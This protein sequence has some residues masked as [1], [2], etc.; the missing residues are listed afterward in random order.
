MQR[1]SGLLFIL[2]LFVILGFGIVLAGGSRSI[3]HQPNYAKITPLPK[4]SQ[5]T[6]YGDGSG[7]ANTTV[8]NGNPG[9]SNNLQLENFA[10]ITATPAPPTPTP[11]KHLTCPPSDDNGLEVAPDCRC[12]DASVTC[13]NGQPFGDDGKPLSG[14]IGSPPMQVDRL[15][16]SRF[17]PGD[18]KYCVAKPVIYLYPSKPTYVDVKVISTGQVTISDPFYPPDGWKNVFAYPNGDLLYHATKYR[19]LFYETE[20]TTYKKPEKGIVIPSRDLENQLNRILDRLGLIGTEK[21]EFLEFWVPKLLALKSPYIFFSLIDQSEKEKIDKVI[22]LPKPTMSIAFLA[23]FKPITDPST[24]NN[25]LIIPPA[26]IRKGFV[27]V[28]WGG[29]LD[30]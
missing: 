5:M 2:L 1:S 16:G 27:S 14:S 10:Y 3:P 21:I 18:G 19:E 12:I 20:V 30:N 4:D 28:E 26:P 23:Y 22:I 8:T 24:Y 9:N 15:C 17:A 29:S 25:T 7:N 11:D 6:T 13:K